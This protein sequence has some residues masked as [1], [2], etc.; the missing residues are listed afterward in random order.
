M[1]GGVEANCMHRLATTFIYVTHDQV[2]AMSL[3]DRIVV[4]RD[5]EIEQIGAPRAVYDQPATRFVAEFIGSPPMNF[6]PATAVGPLA[7]GAAWLGV[8]PEHLTIDSQSASGP[9][10][11]SVE[12][13]ITLIEDLGADA[14]VHVSLAEADGATVIARAAQSAAGA[15]GDMA[16]THAP[17]AALRR[18]DEAGRAVS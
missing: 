5:G 7:N 14:Y 13:R 6:L 16:S 3:A 9:G 18:F 15:I 17:A 2:E 10:D 8:R 12:G 1:R 4:M 11:L